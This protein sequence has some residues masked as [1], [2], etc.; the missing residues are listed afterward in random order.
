MV[1]SVPAA[2]CISRFSR[3]LKGE[4]EHLSF[5]GA[6]DVGP[7]ADS[8]QAPAVLVQICLNPVRQNPYINIQMTSQGDGRGNKQN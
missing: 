3:S 4:H 7:K 8:V 6:D 5:F 1:K 2:N